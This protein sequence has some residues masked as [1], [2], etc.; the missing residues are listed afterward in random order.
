MSKSGYQ[1][2]VISDTSLKELVF[3]KGKYWDAKKLFEKGDWDSINGKILICPFDIKNLG[4]FSYD[5][6]VGN[7]AFAIKTRQ[8]ISISKEKRII[9]RPSDVFLVLSKEYIGL[10][11]EFVGSV[12]PRFSFVREGIIQ[13]MTKIDPTWYGKIVVAIVNHSRNPFQLKKGQPFCTLVIHRLDKPCSR[14]LN[15]QDTLEL[16]KESIEYF[17]KTKKEV[18]TRRC[19][20]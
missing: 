8:K 12:M 4:P 16:G 9:I 10:P 2:C 1:M 15:S 3:P 19:L 11:R 14:I 17:L 7:E 18:K 13:S 20:R 6:C 5:L